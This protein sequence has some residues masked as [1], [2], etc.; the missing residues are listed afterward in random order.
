MTQR[1]FIYVLAGVNGSGKSSVG[2]ALLREEGLDWFNPDELTRQ[3]KADGLSPGDA[4][5]QAWHTGK[6]LL[7]EAIAQGR[8]HA[9]ETTLG[10]NTITRLLRQ[11]CAS[12]DVI[13]WYIGLESVELNLERIRERVKR[14]G[15]DIPAHKVVERYEKSPLNL[16]TLLKDAARIEI[17]DNSASVAAGGTVAGA[18]LLAAIKWGE[19]V[20]PRDVRELAALPGWVQPII[21]AL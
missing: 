16:I 9:F 1:P 15:H 17:H 14:G 10:G 4:N 13:V 5:A 2:G 3:L 7:E 20:E 11:A 19:L 6:R 8:N 18:R 12:H 21:G